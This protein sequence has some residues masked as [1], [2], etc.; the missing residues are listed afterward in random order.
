[1]YKEKRIYSERGMY[2]VLL[3]RS[4]TTPRGKVQ[5]PPPPG[6]YRKPPFR[7]HEQT[8]KLNK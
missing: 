2:K 8:D 5:S 1:M 6:K 3:T 4:K 7:L